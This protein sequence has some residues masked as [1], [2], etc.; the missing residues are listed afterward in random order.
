MSYY[1]WNNIDDFDA[2]HDPVKTGLGLPKYGVNDAT[3]EIDT[4]AQMTVNYSLP[5]IEA[6]GV[7][8]IV[9]KHIADKYSEGIGSITDAPQ[10]LKTVINEAS[11]I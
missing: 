2:W 9:E 6:D 5:I 8:A 10:S 4:D 11:S 3:S 1:K 7:Y